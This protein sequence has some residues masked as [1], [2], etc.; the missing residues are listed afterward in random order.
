MGIGSRGVF[1][2]FAAWVWLL[3]TGY[4]ELNLEK[5]PLPLPP[6]TLLALYAWNSNYW[7]S[8]SFHQRCAG[9]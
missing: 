1:C 9:L 3:L 7:W 2:G 5:F 4:W 8:C 6:I